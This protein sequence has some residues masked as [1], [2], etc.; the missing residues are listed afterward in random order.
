MVIV[1]HKREKYNT[2]KKFQEIIKCFYKEN[3]VLSKLSIGA[4]TY[5]IFYYVSYN[6]PELWK[7]ASV[8]VDILFQLS[9]ALIANFIF[10]IF[11]MYI[12]N[13]KRNSKIQPIIKRKISKIC[14]HI[15][16]PFPEITKKYLKI[17]KNLNELTDSDIKLIA[18][19]YRPQDISTVQVAFECR[20]LTYN[21]YFK[22]CFEEIDGIVQ[23]LIF[24]YAP[25]LNEE[26]RDILILLKEN[27]FRQLFD[28]P[29]MN[30]FDTTGIQGGA[31]L[32][33]FKKY[34]DIYEEILNV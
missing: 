16:D 1:M 27:P 30:L 26:Q 3:K 15:N 7:N 28:N 33:T 22:L 32:Y 12:P 17:K 20:N 34:K 24:A 14:A 25:Y 19:K 18:E 6:I 31:T 13:F 4:V 11:Q 10:F 9:L 8:V 5:V 2:V 21:Q 29:L 23:E